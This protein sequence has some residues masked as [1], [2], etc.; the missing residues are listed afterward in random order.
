MNTDQM[1]QR[2]RLFIR[3]CLLAAL[4]GE[5]VAQ[6]VSRPVP[7]S[8]S[9]TEPARPD[10]GIEPAARAGVPPRLI[11]RMGE[12]VSC[13]VEP[14]IVAEVGSH[15]DG[16]LERVAVER[17]DR[18]AKGQVVATIKSWVE[19]AEVELKKARVEFGKRKNERNEELFRQQLISEQ[20]KDEMETEYRLNQAEL[21]REL[22]NLKL[23]TIV[24]PLDGVVV[25]R[26]LSA[27][28][29]IRTDKSKVLK[30]AQIDPLNV[31]VIAPLELFGSVKLGANYDVSLEPL[32]KGAH[33]AKVVI[34]DRVIDAASGTFG[35]RLE[36]PNPDF[37]IP[38]GIR[39]RVRFGR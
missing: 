30:L 25:E 3:A 7:Q 14:H 26:Y 5:T 21:K 37:R 27:G 1:Q 34:V 23:R 35:V 31:E 9:R 12:G 22:E 18:V 29:L 33:R 32:V 6:D 20:E 2:L 36:L 17:G 38:A 28:E 13:M 11:G 4:A 15:V 24:S 39:C 8:R 19:Q 16:V 10:P